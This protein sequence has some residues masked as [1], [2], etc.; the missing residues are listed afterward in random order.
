MIL[1]K[2]NIFFPIYTT[3]FSAHFVATLART[4]SDIGYQIHIT[5]PADAFSDFL[6]RYLGLQHLTDAAVGLLDIQKG[7]AFG[8]LGGG[9]RGLRLC[10]GMT[11]IERF[12]DIQEF[13]LAIVKGNP[14]TA[15]GYLDLLAGLD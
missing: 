14:V 8:L 11:F 1:A 5:W 3:S 9:C 2:I 12:L 7:F 4:I 6:M 10:G 13:A 15:I